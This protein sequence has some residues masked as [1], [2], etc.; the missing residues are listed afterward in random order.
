MAVARALGARRVIAID[1]QQGR[2]DFARGYAATDIHVA[3]PLQEGESKED[4][5]KRHVREYGLSLCSV[6]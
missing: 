6:A 2:L 4:Y 5:S 3:S 1:V